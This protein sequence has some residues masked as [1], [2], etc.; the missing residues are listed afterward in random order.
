MR[1]KAFTLIELLVVIAIIA[2]LAAILFPVFASAKE[3]AKKT[4]TLSNYKQVALAM[5]IYST[6]ADDTFPLQAGSNDAGA[7]RWCFQHRVPANWQNLAPFNTIARNNQDSQFPLNSILPYVKSVDMYQ[8][9]GIVTA[10]LATNYALA[11]KARAK[12]GLAY[13]GMLNAYPGTSVANPA[14]T[15][16]VSATLWKQNRDGFGISSPELWCDSGSGAAC[17][18]NTNAPPQGTGYNDGTGL[19]FAAG[20]N[21]GYGYVWWGFAGVANTTWIYGKGMHFASTDSSARFIN[22]GDLPKW[23]DPNGPPA[24]ATGNAN[25]NPW[26]AFDPNDIP[27]S[28]YWMTDCAAPGVDATGTVHPATGWTVF[29]YPCYYRPDSEFSWTIEAD[30]GQIYG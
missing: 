3:A 9:S 1:K 29:F 19:C 15:P 11:V 5:N 23:N 25:K 21:A 27:G 18:F 22:I 17:Q 14:K 2:I 4:S 16:I 24:Q 26:S 6:D 7:M 20:T 30:Y 12:V 28:P 13:N 8:Q 10:S